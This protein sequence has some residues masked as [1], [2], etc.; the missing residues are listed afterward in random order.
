MTDRHSGYLVTLA[1]DIREDDAQPLLAAMRLL[2]GVIAVEPIINL[3][4]V[5]IAEA[6]ANADWRDRILEM[7]AGLDR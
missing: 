6:R 5:M 7:L 4:E 2:R 1:A 3:P